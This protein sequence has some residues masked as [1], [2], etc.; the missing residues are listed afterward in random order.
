MEE[1]FF[2]CTILTFHKNFKVSNINM[3]Y[4][5][6]II[7]Y[8]SMLITQVCQVKTGPKICPVCLHLKHITWT[9][10]AMDISSQLKFNQEVVMFCI[11]LISSCSDSSLR[12][13]LSTISCSSLHSC[14]HLVATFVASSSS[15]LG[16]LLPADSDIVKQEQKLL[17]TPS[18]R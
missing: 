17:S 5:K 1:T 2:F 14:I 12:N 16:P 3:A 7:N 11:T 9:L 10:C 6:F 4:N 15:G 8:V 13:L 18:D